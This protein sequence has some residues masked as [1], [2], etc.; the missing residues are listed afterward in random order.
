LG[1]HHCRTLACQSILATALSEK[2]RDEDRREAELLQLKT[3]KQT[4][5][6]SG[7]YS[8][9]VQ[10]AMAKLVKI[11]LNL[12]NID[13]AERVQATI[14]HRRARGLWEEDQN[15]DIVNEVEE[16]APDDTEED[17]E[18]KPIQ[19]NDLYKTLGVGKDANEIDIKKAYRKLA[20]VN[21]PDRNPGDLGAAQ[22]FKNVGKAY[23]ILS[24][25]QERAR[26]DRLVAALSANSEGGGQGYGGSEAEEPTTSAAEDEPGRC[27]IPSTEW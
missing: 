2:E 25:P 1:P 27:K 15:A 14:L 4:E 19:L 7:E 9:A 21:H 26:Y 16:K 18:E 20:I 8:M 22:R 11:L 5:L 17:K 23:E 3:V 13:Q 10:K 12:G 6:R 24:I